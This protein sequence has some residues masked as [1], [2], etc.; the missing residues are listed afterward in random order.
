MQPALDLFGH[1]RLRMKA[2]RKPKNLTTIKDYCSE[3]GAQKLQER[4][5]EYWRERGHEI[6]ITLVTQYFHKAMRSVRTDVRSNMVNG[7]EER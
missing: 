1:P 2:P 3:E 5:E 4:I 6:Q 7:L